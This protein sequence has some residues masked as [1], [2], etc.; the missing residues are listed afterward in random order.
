M[1]AQMADRHGPAFTIRLGFQKIMVLSS[2]E[3]VRECFTVYD[4]AFS[5]RPSLTAS[6]LLAYNSAM[7]GF[8][9]YGAYWRDVRKI[10][11]VELL[12]NQRLDLLKHIR[13]YELRTSIRGLYNL[14]SS[15]GC[16]QNGVVVDMK[17]WFGHLTLN[18]LMKMVTGKRFKAE[19]A[20][21]MRNCRKLNR[22]Y[23]E[24][25]GAFAVSDAFPLTS[26]LDIDG[27]KK[28]MR[29]T[30][31]SF[32]ELFSKLLDD[33]KQKRMSGEEE[34]QEQDFMDGMLNTV[35]DIKGFSFDA[36]TI[37]KATCLV[38]HS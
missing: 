16:P 25:L 6:K 17:D 23:V 9:A 8:S 12:S 19:E 33:H 26:W 3:M 35:H 7:L 1:L 10:A 13:D 4:K 38:R 32:D 24:L 27:Y 14:W 34:K 31:K 2:W 15:Q 29:N 30:A 22:R 11:T 21:Q 5:N 37:I 18:I 20:V 36:D 28:A